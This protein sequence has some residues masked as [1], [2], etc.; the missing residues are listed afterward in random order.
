MGNYLSCTLA[1]A[2]MGGS[3]TKVVLPNGQIRRFDGAV[4]AAE[5]MLDAPGNFLT[6]AKCMHLGQ[7]LTALSADEE[8]EM[9]GIYVMLPMDRLN[10]VA[11]PSD[12]ARLLVLASKEAKRVPAS[13]RVQPDSAPDVPK[14]ARLDEVDDPDAAAEIG[15]F[16]HRMSCGRSRRPTLE[17]IQEE[18]SYSS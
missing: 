7:R 6:E 10:A 8:L 4:S 13:A 1:K 11:T 12:M 2:T 17:T 3:A 15:E 18:N 5:L 9:A 14:T 16:K